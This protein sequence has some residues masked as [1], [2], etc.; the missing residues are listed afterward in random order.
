VPNN[1]G[2]AGGAASGGARATG[3]ANGGAPNAGNNRGGAGSAPQQG[4]ARGQGGAGVAGV[5]F[6]GDM[7]RNVPGE[8]GDMSA[9][10]GMPQAAT[11]PAAQTKEPFLQQLAAATP[12]ARKNLIGEQLYGQIHGKQPMLAGK[13]T[14]MLLDGMEDS[15]LLHLLESPVE[16]ENRIR[17]A[18]EV[19]EQHNKKAGGPQ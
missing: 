18:I 2:A 13:I 4:G 3:P 15:E 6:R 12:A 10:V 8:G 19:L 14:G 1:A 7:A 16:L 11:A 9:A 17:E 5:Q